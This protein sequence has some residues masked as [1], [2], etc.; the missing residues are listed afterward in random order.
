MTEIKAMANAENKA[1][2]FFKTYKTTSNYDA[3]KDMTI[4]ELDKLN[5]MIIATIKEK[6]EE[7]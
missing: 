3:L 4:F 6:R 7:I 2:K 5:K 1:D